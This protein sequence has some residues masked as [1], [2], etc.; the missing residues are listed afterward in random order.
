MADS[1]QITSNPPALT[2]NPRRM[3]S[4]GTSGIISFGPNTLLAAQRRLEQEEP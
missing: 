3:L 1:N 2:A 4:D